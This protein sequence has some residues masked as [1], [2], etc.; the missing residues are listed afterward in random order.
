MNTY[1]IFSIIIQYYFCF[2]L[3]FP[4][5]AMG[6]SFSWLLCPIHIHQCGCIF[7][8]EQIIIAGSKRCQAAPVL[9]NSH[10]SK[11]PSFLLL[12]IAL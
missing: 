8:S 4:A 1:F 9:V 11:E 2:A 7:V 5:L 10:F 6:S 3:V 12:E